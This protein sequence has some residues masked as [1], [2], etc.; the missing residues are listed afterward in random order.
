MWSTAINWILSSE[1]LRIWRTAYAVYIIINFGAMY[2]KVGIFSIYFVNFK[3]LKV[4]SEGQS[5]LCSWQIFQYIFLKLPISSFSYLLSNTI[6]GI[7]PVWKPLRRPWCDFLKRKDMIINLKYA[8]SFICIWFAT[9]W[10][11]LKIL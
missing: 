6:T 1:I 3:L 9:N 7:I 8:F 10:G 2:G 5:F 11:R 4:E